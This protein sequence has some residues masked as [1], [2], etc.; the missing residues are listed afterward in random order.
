MADK[1]H[2][3]SWRCSRCHGSDKAQTTPG[4]GT[5][6]ETCK[7]NWRAMFAPTDRMT[8]IVGVGEA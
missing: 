7:A 2:S 3:V 4:D 6:C 1:A 5:W 8:D